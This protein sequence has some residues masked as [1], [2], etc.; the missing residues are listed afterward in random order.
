MRN[1]P[2]RNL[3][4]PGNYEQ[5]FAEEEKPL[6]V[7]IEYEVGEVR[8]GI[9]EDEQLT[10]LVRAISA[11]RH[12]VLKG[13]FS[14]E[15]HTYKADDM[16]DCVR[17]AKIA[18]DFSRCAA[19]V[20]ASVISKPHGERVVMDSGA[21]ALVSQNRPTGICATS[22]SDPKPHLSDGEPV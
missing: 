20:L 8:S 9:V 14:H 19:T 3:R 4:K 12:V 1:C 22:R 13:I 11:C 17:K 21:K 5:V 18:Y 7:L 2:K 6:E 16:E 15:G 10:D